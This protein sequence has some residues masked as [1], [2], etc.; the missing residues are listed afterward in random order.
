MKV[1]SHDPLPLHSRLSTDTGGTGAD[2]QSSRS[3]HAPPI[4]HKHEPLGKGW[5]MG[6]YQ[7][8]TMVDHIMGK[9]KQS[10]VNIPSTLEERPG[11]PEDD[12][13]NWISATRCLFWA[14][15]EVARRLALE[16]DQGRWVED[17]VCIAV[18]TQEV[19]VVDGDQ[20]DERDDEDECSYGKQSNRRGREKRAR[21]EEGYKVPQ[22][23]GRELWVQPGPAIRHGLAQGRGG[24]LSVAM[25]ETYEI[26]L[27]LAEESK[28]VLYFGR[29]FAESIPLDKEFT[30]EVSFR[31]PFLQFQAAS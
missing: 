29:V 24:K 25:K 1:F 28:E 2:M 18:I 11:T 17:K 22:P 3:A 26:A 27:K 21:D 8:H 6:P 13:S 20:Q 4:K 12:K 9:L 19:A 30:R 15:W 10:L 7:R 14:L 31:L 5:E 23:Q 16:D